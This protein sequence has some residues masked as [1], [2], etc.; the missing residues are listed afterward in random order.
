LYWIAGQERN[1]SAALL[2]VNVRP[3]SFA[4][5]MAELLFWPTEDRLLFWQRLGG[6]ATALHYGRIYGV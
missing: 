6:L 3:T 1:V 4:H 5:I 2:F